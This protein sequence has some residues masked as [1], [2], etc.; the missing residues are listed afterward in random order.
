A[1]NTL[2]HAGFAVETVNSGPAALEAF[3]AQRF[4]AVLLD[5]VMPDMDGFEVCQRIRALPHGASV[6]LLM[7]TGRTDPESIERAYQLGATDFITKPINWA[8]LSH[9]VRYALRASAAAEA[10]RRAADRLVRAQRA[11]SLGNWMLTPDG[12]AELSDE[13]LRILDMDP[14][15]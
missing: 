1:A 2:Q 6:P 4:D 9:R 15:S 14:G 8:L 10:T 13:L 3:A 5:L 7:F 12:G 11:A